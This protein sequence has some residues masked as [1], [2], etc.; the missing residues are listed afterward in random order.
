MGRVEGKVV[1][2]T[3]AAQGMGRAIAHTC[4]KEGAKVVFAD[5]NDAGAREAAEAAVQAFSGEAIGMALDV[6]SR[7]QTAAVV[8]E[9]ASRWG[10]L[11]VMF[12]NAGVNRPQKF[13]ETTK[14]NWDFIMD[15]NGWG[16]MIG[17]QEAAKQMILQGRQGELA[18]KI[19][20]TGSIVGKAGLDPNVVPYSI[21]KYGVAALTEMGAREFA[22]HD[23]TVNSYAPGVVDTPLWETLDE[24]LME[25]GVSDKKGQAMKDF[26]A[27][28]LRGRAATP[29]DIVGTAL[30]LASSDSDYMTGQ[31]I[32]IDGGMVFL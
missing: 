21:S 24:Q 16:V 7:D 9:A 18:G 29:A 14:E 13:L 3:G 30:Y 25:L 32:M 27:G 2:V 31:T 6:R 20:N 19:V 17:M 1:V 15:V 10:R 22:S 26:S 28:I 4:V 8:A 12:N 23:I 11:D 5:M